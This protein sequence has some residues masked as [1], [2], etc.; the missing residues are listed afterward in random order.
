M[1]VHFY[2]TENQRSTIGQ[3][4]SS[5]KKV[6]MSMYDHGKSIMHHN[7]FNNSI[8]NPNL[9]RSQIQAPTRATQ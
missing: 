2:T 6:L 3:T 1:M 8:M 4:T 7:K 5:I 9:N